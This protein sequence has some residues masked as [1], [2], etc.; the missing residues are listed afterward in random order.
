MDP[1]STTTTISRK[2]RRRR[3]WM[4]PLLPPPPPPPTYGSGSGKWAHHHVKHCGSTPPFG[5]LELDGGHTSIST[6]DTK[7]GWMHTFFSVDP[8]SASGQRAFSRVALSLLRTNVRFPGRSCVSPGPAR[9]SSGGP[10]FGSSTPEFSRTAPPRKKA[11]RP[12]TEKK[13]T[14]KT[15]AERKRK[16]CH[17][18]HTHAGPKKKQ[19]HPRKRTPTRNMTITNRKNA[20]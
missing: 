10:A 4:A 7:Q 12:R 8:V 5:D 3:R 6:Y 11:R 17:P 16:Q 14:E 15:H 20:S 13:P 2:G 9:V 19:H 18:K 1:L